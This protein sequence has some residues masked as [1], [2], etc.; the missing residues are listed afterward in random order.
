ME[1]R[2]LPRGSTQ[3]LNFISPEESSHVYTFPKE[4]NE[5]E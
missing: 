4:I 2:N 3:S 5:K 1:A